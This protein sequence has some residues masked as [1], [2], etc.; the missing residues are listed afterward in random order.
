M[1]APQRG[2]GTQRRAGSTPSTSAAEARAPAAQDPLDGPSGLAPVRSPIPLYHRIYMI[3]REGITTGA[4][5]V[6]EAIPTEAELMERFGV[7]RITARRALDELSDEGLVDRARGRGTIVS[8][9]AAAQIGGAPIVAG[10]E[11]LMANLSVIG[12]QTTVTICEFEHVPAPGAVAAE[13]GLKTGEMV[14]R[15]VR[16]RSLAE[17]PFS[18][19]TTYVLDR[20]GRTYTRDELASIPMIDLISR[21]GANVDSVKQSIT[22][23]LA[24]DVAAQRLAVQP[25]SALL[26]LR[27]TFFDDRNKGVYTAELFYR[28]DRFEYRMTLSRGADNRFRLDRN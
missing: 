13:L 10:I 4:Y 1:S 16:V 27:R 18:L 26:K 7:S 19:S 9:S 2:S 23:T 17:G 22:A 6:G 8:A 5:K 12:R 11:G 25:G 15:A 28:P 20:I 14:Q 3:L 21:A 24:D